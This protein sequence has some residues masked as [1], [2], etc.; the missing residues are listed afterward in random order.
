MQQPSVRLTT[1]GLQPSYRGSTALRRVISE[2]P[3]L[4]FT[5]RDSKPSHRGSTPRDSQPSYRG[6]TAVQTNTTEHSS[7]SKVKL[8]TYDAQVSYQGS[9]VTH[10]AITE[11]PKARNTTADSQTSYLASTAT[12]TT[13]TEHSEVTEPKVRLTTEDFQVSHQGSIAADVVTNEQ[14]KSRLSTVDLQP[15]YRGPSATHV[16]TTENPKVSQLKVRLTAEDSTASHQGSVTAGVATSE[17]PSYRGPTETLTPTTEHPTLGEPKVR[18]S[19]DDILQCWR[20]GPS[21]LRLQAEEVWLRVNYTGNTSSSPLLHTP[22]T[23]RL[24]VKGQG[25]E[26]VSLLIFNVTCFS[27]NRL[28]VHSR[29]RVRRSFDCDPALWMVPG[30]ELVMTSNLADVSIVI[31]DVHAAFSLLARFKTLS[32]IKSKNKKLEIRWVTKYVGT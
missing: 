24:Q 3:K 32:E 16:I 26:T 6:S 11:Q 31:D 8:T 27:P 30:M 10:A 17:Q 14:L 28:L 4:R 5:A 7:Q 19:T 20:G 12:H 1:Q 29:M 2:H 9:I 25:H 21:N 22:S 13:T 15:S 23:C 18:L